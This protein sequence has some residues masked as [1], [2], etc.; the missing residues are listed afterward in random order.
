MLDRYVSPHSPH[1]PSI[2]DVTWILYKGVSGRE[3]KIEKGLEGKKEGRKEGGPRTFFSLFASSSSS[4]LLFIHLSAP[5]HT[6]T[7]SE[8]TNLNHN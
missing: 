8:V 3:T 6:F 5:T 4:F 2:V 1:G 7:H